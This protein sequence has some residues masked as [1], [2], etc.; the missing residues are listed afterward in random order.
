MANLGFDLLDFWPLTLNFCMDIT[1]VTGN[2]SWKFQHDTMIIWWEHSAKGVKGT[3]RQTDRQTDDSNFFFKRKSIW[4]CYLQNVGHFSGLNIGLFDAYFSSRC[5]TN[6]NL[7]ES[8]TLAQCMCQSSTPIRNMYNLRDKIYKI[9][10]NSIS[11]PCVEQK[12]KRYSIKYFRNISWDLYMSII[13]QN[14]IYPYFA[15]CGCFG[16]H[17]PVSSPRCSMSI[18]SCMFHKDPIVH[19]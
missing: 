14:E 6:P 12:N 5:I 15:W 4:K 1:S 11:K 18:S 10:Y 2:H 9:S 7:T 17:V 13:S 16:P 8:Q 19:L 3:D